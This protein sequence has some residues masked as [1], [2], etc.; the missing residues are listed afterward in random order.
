MKQNHI[1]FTRA[2]IEALRV[3]L[4]PISYTIPKRAKTQRT[5]KTSSK[6]SSSKA[7]EN[8]QA[9]RATRAGRRGLPCLQKKG[10]S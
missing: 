2:I 9:L 7:N 6:E 5:P 3:A 4:Y 1:F 10:K 8:T